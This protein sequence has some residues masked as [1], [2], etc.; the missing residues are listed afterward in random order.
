MNLGLTHMLSLLVSPRHS[1][2]VT[3][4]VTVFQKQGPVIYLSLQDKI[5]TVC[6]DI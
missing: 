3:E 6:K 2:Y 5:R 1:G 4:R